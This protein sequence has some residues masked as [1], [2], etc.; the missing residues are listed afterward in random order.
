MASVQSSKPVTYSD[1]VNVRECMK[2]RELGKKESELDGVFKILKRPEF[3]AFSLEG[4]F[5][6]S[7]IPQELLQKKV[8]TNGHPLLTFMSEDMKKQFRNFPTVLCADGTHATNRAGHTLM[9]IM[10]YG[11]LIS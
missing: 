4:V 1:V 7:N 10:V 6:S 2:A 11:K 8:A 5:D 3:P 9:S